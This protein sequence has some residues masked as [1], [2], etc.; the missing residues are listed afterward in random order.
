MVSRPRFRF[1]SH[2]II[3]PPPGQLARLS[4]RGHVP[5]TGDDTQQIDDHHIANWAQ[6][7][8]RRQSF[9]RSAFHQCHAE[10]ICSAWKEICDGQK[11][12]SDP[13]RERN[14]RYWCIRANC[15]ASTVTR[16][17]SSPWACQPPSRAWRPSSRAWWWPSS[18]TRS[19]WSSSSP[20]P[21]WHSS[22]PA[23]RSF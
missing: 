6:D 4:P 9:K 11:G 15:Y 8:A 12:F 18:S 19:G 20:R 22:S 23:R 17:S 1:L 21:W 7:G 13:F 3:P 2:L 16:P 10:E 14:S 5:R